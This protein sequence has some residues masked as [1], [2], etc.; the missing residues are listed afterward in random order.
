MLFIDLEKV[1]DK[2]LKNIIWWALEKKSVPTKYV[3]IIKDMYINIVTC[4]RL[5]DSKSD[6]FSIKIILH[7]GTA[8]SPYVF[9]LVMDE[10]TNDI[11]GDISWCMLFVDDVVLID[12]STIGVDQKLDLLI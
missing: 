6:I 1:Y 7:Q 12:K 2:I 8:L 4:V 11:Q 3:T 5:C 9:T 10:I